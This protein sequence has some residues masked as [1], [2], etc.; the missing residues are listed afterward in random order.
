MNATSIEILMVEDNEGDVILATE[1]LSGAKIANRL[2][3]VQNGAEALE[4][5]YR[6]GKYSDAPRPDL[7]LLD[8]NLPGTDGRE[9]LAKI[10]ADSQLQAIPVVVLTSSRAEQ[11]VARA[12]ALHANCYIVKP[13]DFAGLLEI[14][15]SIE[16]FWLSVVT[17]PS[18][19]S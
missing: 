13:V 2:S 11:D 7:I 5:L 16:Q 18:N 10:K 17:L 4:F 12:Y 6:R 3:V 19:G 8:L 9:V 14:V 15:Q 1:A